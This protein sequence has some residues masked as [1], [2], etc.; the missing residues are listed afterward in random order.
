MGTLAVRS[1]Y[2]LLHGNFRALRVG[3]P[4]TS[5]WDRALKVLL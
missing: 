1:G 3:P 4:V 2:Q 5:A